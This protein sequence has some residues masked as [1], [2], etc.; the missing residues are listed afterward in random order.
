[1]KSHSQLIGIIE[2]FPHPATFKAADTGKYI[3]SNVANSKHFGV[4]NPE[5]MVGLTVHDLN[6]AQP[7]WGTRFAHKIAEID[8]RVRDE[9][10]VV[11]DKRSI[12]VNGGELRHEEMIKFPALGT[13][14]H[15]LG[16]VTYS[17]DLTPA[18]SYTELYRQYLCFYNKMDAIKRV[19]VHLE[20]G[21]SFQ[22][23]PTEAQFRVFLEKAQGCATKEIARR[24]GLSPRTVESHVTALRNKLVDG[25]LRR[26]L[27]LI[28]R[29]TAQCAS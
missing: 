15:V 26:V 6:F 10:T 18:L 22:L 5:E 9:K 20:V 16:I 24:L 23:L 1:M 29:G 11:S 4:L 8:F 13:S 7:A 27:S 25:D 19:L 21:E 28:K 12:L 14:E 3:F 17:Q 2:K